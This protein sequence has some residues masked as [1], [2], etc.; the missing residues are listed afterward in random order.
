M[1]PL[2]PN[3]AFLESGRG[4]SPGGAFFCCCSFPAM[5]TT[6]TATIRTIR[7]IASVSMVAPPAKERKGWECLL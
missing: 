5:K 7:P 6:A 2:R 4:Y 3:E 1:G